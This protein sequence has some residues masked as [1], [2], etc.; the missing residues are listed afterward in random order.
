MYNVVIYMSLEY[1][2]SNLADKRFQED[3][4]VKQAAS[5]RQE[6]IDMDFF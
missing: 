3:A 2:I 5:S 4:D 1:F 6:T